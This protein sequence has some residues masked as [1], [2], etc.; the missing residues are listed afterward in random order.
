MT[1]AASPQPSPD[2]ESKAAK[3]APPP[4]TGPRDPGDAWVVRENGD[5]YWG[6][7]GSAGLVAWGPN[8][9]ILLQH[10]VEWSHF[11]NTWGIP[12]GARHKNEAALTAALRESH[13]EAA[14]PSDDLQ[15]LFSW[16]YDLGDWSYTTIIAKVTRDFDPQINDPE[17]N[18]LAWVPV[19]E[20]AGLE[21]HPRFGEAWPEIKAALELKPVIIIDIANL[22]GSHADGWWRNRAAKAQ[23]LITQLGNWRSQGIPAE[24]LK[25]PGYK[26]WPEI[27]TVVEGQAKRITLDAPDG[28]NIAAAPGEGDDE[29]VAQAEKATSLGKAVTVVTSDKGLRERLGRVGAAAASGPINIV[30]VGALAQLRR[31]A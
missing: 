30:N 12:G 21:L 19:S 10:R 6:K 5:R 7:Y 25:L 22:M 2:N 24:L 23:S 16:L 28:I 14:V 1:E 27:I 3:K 9:G 17:S 29:I 13:E 18:E 15:V 8:R 20:V 11:G 26:W 4:R 31:K